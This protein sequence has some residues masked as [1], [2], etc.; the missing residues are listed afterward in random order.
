MRL[1]LLGLPGPCLGRTSVTSDL[2]VANAV[3]FLGRP[4]SCPEP[5][6]SFSVTMKPVSGPESV[7]FIY[8]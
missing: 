5:K 3:V 6:G 7:F 1:A 2:E 4:R 8:I